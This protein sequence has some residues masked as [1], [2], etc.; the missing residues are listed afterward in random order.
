MPVH[1]LTSKPD[2][3]FRIKLELE[4]EAG[5][6][7]FWPQTKLSFVVL[8][9]TLA[10]VRRRKNDLVS[11]LSLDEMHELTAGEWDPP[12]KQVEHPFARRE[13]PHLIAEFV[14]DKVI[15]ML[16]D[17]EPVAILGDPRR[18]IWVP[19]VPSDDQTVHESIIGHAFYRR[20]LIDHATA[21]KIVVEWLENGTRSSSVAYD[22]F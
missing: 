9:D 22:K 6:Y 11:V 4:P 18:P 8:F 12:S 21:R 16:M 15:L 10:L 7:D 1:D 5:A 2:L 17:R 3:Q 14:D 13:V 20:N 19:R